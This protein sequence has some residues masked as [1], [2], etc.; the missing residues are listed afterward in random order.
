MIIAE[1]YAKSIGRD[2]LLVEII[3]ILSSLKERDIQLLISPLLSSPSSSPATRGA[4][5]TPLPLMGR[6]KVESTTTPLSPPPLA[7]LSRGTPEFGSGGSECIMQDLE[8][9]EAEF[10]EVIVNTVWDLHLFLLFSVAHPRRNQL[11]CIAIWSCWTCWV[12]VTFS[13]F[14]HSISQVL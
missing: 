3:Q 9:D 7:S 10:V 8:G 1:L 14:V 5:T 4:T 2:P 6:T 12:C 11:I 13:F